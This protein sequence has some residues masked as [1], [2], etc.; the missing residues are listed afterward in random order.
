MAWV[1]VAQYSLVWNANT[2]VGTIGLWFAGAQVNPNVPH[3]TLPN[4]R[5]D[6]YAAIAQT[7]RGDTDHKL[8]FDPQL[9][10]FASGIEPI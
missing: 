4:L 6:Q 9:G 8:F 5:A 7:L 3:Q 1:N 2:N 10:V